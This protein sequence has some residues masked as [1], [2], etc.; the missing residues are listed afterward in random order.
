M[1]GGSRPH[2]SGALLDEKLRR[3]FVVILVLASLGVGL[4]VSRAV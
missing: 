3:N 4:Q 2:V 1:K